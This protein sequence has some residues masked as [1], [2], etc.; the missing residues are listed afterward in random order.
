MEQAISA[1]DRGYRARKFAFRWL[2]SAPGMTAQ[3]VFGWLPLLI[4]FLSA[5]QTF[6]FKQS[7][8]CG[9][10]NFK[11]VMQDPISAPFSLK[12]ASQHYEVSVKTYQ[13]EHTYKPNGLLK[14]WYRVRSVY[15]GMGECWRNTLYYVL[16]D[17][18]IIFFVPIIISILLMEMPSWLIRIMMILWWIPI[19]DMAS[20]ILLKYF[21]NV[22]YGLL[23]GL[24]REFYILIGKPENTWVFPR[25]LNSPQLAMICIVLPSLIMFMPGL[26]YIAALQGIPQDLYDA[27]EIDGCG[28]FQKIWHITLPRLRPLIS[29]MMIF[30]LIS[31]FQIM[32]AILIMTAGG[33]ANKTIT[34]SY[35]V[36]KL[37]FEYLEIGKGNALAI[38]F[39]LFLMFLT[40]L[41][42]TLF[43]ENVDTGES[44]KTV[45]LLKEGDK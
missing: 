41:Q 33:P 18:G 16:L 6:H 36:Y 40:V 21:Y 37:S 14:A 15:Y 2:I 7:T 10:N 19:A 24:I 9:I 4:G 13:E 42:R 8:W 29:T 45:K 3:L 38:L 44:K 12:A 32:E 20:T 5:F 31:A 22:D 1:V 43:K 35:Y 26:V 39:F 30:A 28:F 17:L 11:N 34:I 25:W 27:A 23:N